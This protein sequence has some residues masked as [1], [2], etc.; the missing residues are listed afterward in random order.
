MLTDIQRRQ[1]K[2]VFFTFIEELVVGRFHLERHNGSRTVLVEVFR[3]IFGSL[4][5]L[6]FGLEP[7]EKTLSRNEEK[8]KEYREY[9][10]AKGHASSVWPA[11]EETLDG[12]ATTGYYSKAESIWKPSVKPLDSSGA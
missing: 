10:T 11:F 7:T 3:N 12:Q 5:C 8:E 2:A 1:L 6:R 4:H 9:L